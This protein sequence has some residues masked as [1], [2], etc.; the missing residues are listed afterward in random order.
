MT[1]TL[2]HIQ[3]GWISALPIEALLAEIMLD[4]VIDQ[5]I[6]L[7]RNDHNIYT[8][9]RIKIVGSDASHVVAIA[10]LPLSTTGKASA[11]TVANNMHRTFPNLKF[12]IMVGIAGGVWTAKEDV[13]LGDVVVG[14]PDDGGPGIIQYD[15][16][17]SIQNG[18]FVTKGAM[19]KAPDVLRSAAGVLQRKHM[20]RPGGDFV[21]SLEIAEVKRLASRPGVDNLFSKT[22]THQGGSSCENCDE[23]YLQS[24]PQ[25]LDSMPRVHYG[26]IA[27]GDQ[28]VKDAVF[29]EKIR[30]KHGIICFE[31]EAAGLD[32]FPCLVVRGISDYADTH[33]N[34]KWHAYAAATAAAYAKELLSVVPL[35]AVAE[36]PIIEI[37]HWNVP[38]APNPLFTGRESL[39]G[40]MEKHLINASLKKDRPVFVLQGIG[41]AGK[42]EAAIKFATKH[43]DKFWGIFWIDADNLQ[44]LE[45][46]FKE[47]ARMQTPPLAYNTP[48]DVL[49]WLATVKESW[50]L[51]LDNCDDGT[52]DFAKYIPSR[53]GSVILTTRLTD[54][55]NLGTW[56]NLD[57]LGHEIAVKL[58]LRACGFGIND[59]T[60]IPAAQSIVS[61][62]GQH[63]LAL[64]H[65]GAYIKK[66]YCTLGE[67][68]DFFRNERT[69]LMKFQPTQL[70]S[71]Y[72]S[73]YT[74]FEVSA[75]ALASSHDHDNHLALKLLDILA[76]LDRDAVEEDLF[77]RAFDE[78]YKLESESGLVWEENA[79]QRVR[80]RVSS[81]TEEDLSR[82]HHNNLNELD[83]P[84]S[85]SNVSCTWRGEYLPS[86]ETSSR[87]IDNRTF[88]MEDSRPIATGDVVDH[89]LPEF[90]TNDETGET[91]END[92]DDEDDKDEDEEDDGEID[93]LD[94]WHCK[95][96]RES[97]LVERQKFK[98]LRVARTRL[99]DLSLIRVNSNRISMH[100]LVHGWARTRLGKSERQYAW[101]QTLSLLAMSSINDRTWH[102]FTPKLVLHIDT[103]LCKRE[104]ESSSQLHL[105]VVRA[106]YR[107]G[108]HF[109][110]DRKF[111]ASL[112]IFMTISSSYEMQPHTISSKSED[113]EYAK[114]ECLRHLGRFEEMRRCVDQVVRSTIRWFTPESNEVFNSHMLLA[115]YYQDTRRL[116]DAVILLEKL[117]ERSWQI[118]LLEGGHN[119]RLLERSSTTQADLDD[120][121]RAVNVF[122]EKV[123]ISQLYPSEAS[124]QRLIIMK[125]L[126]SA[127]LELGKTELAV[128][129]FKEVLE[130]GALSLSP[131]E[132]DRLIQ[133]DQLAKAYLKLGN[134]QMAA[135]L[136][137]EVV[138]IAASSLPLDDRRRLM[139]M[140]RLAY[141]YLKLRK[142]DKAIKL[143]KEVVKIEAS[144][145][146]VND[147]GRLIHMDRLADGYLKLNKPDKAVTLLEEVVKIATSSLAIDDRDRLIY[148]DRLAAAY[149]QLEQPDKAAAVLE[150]VIAL[151]S[152][153]PND[154]ESLISINRLAEAYLRLDRPDE[155]VALLEE[156]VN[157]YANAH[158]FEPELTDRR[159]LAVKRCLARAYM[160]NLEFEKAANL[161]KQTVE[162]LSQVVPPGHQDLLHCMFQLATILLDRESEEDAYEALSLLEAVHDIGKER[163]SPGDQDLVS[164][165]IVLARAYLKTSQVQRAVEFLEATID[166]ANRDLPLDHGARLRLVS[167]LGNAYLQAGS[168]HKAIGVLGEVVE[169]YRVFFK[170]D[171]GNILLGMRRLA[172]AYTKLD[173]GDKM[174]DANQITVRLY[175]HDQM[176]MIPDHYNRE[177]ESERR[178]SALTATSN[179]RSAY[180]MADQHIKELTKRAAL[181][182]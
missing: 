109:Y 172:E 61:I 181:M 165:Q 22:Y 160:Q 150:Q 155:A 72:G 116:Q 84:Q 120:N 73:V 147:H 54:C 148:V 57:D 140:D 128:P 136:L 99:A 19:N 40:K 55:R 2:D 93:H 92:A 78:C 110:H 143:L 106:L 163:L 5:A 124:P 86:I 101:E 125:R 4:E 170:I 180:S 65:A 177:Q 114:A 166:V 53:G 51:I 133:M 74:T 32:A 79:C 66:G 80:C 18:E 75:K 108:W 89:E 179:P 132:P 24:R 52:I 16:G 171:D 45:E 71:R 47:I 8:Y 25:R 9:G 103:C 100:P 42:S 87:V 6:A 91:Y 29:A 1:L 98:R 113:I 127:Y 43:Q 157:T 142:P 169:L 35:T 77:V 50:L 27:S 178:T 48:K 175:K 58:L 41:G 96:V 118:P 85:T 28:V 83:N 11:A 154:L 176:R 21:S 39:L 164:T 130:I 111:E 159:L 167:M 129:L 144:S 107:L 38:R 138:E 95:K 30:V 153:Q 49:Q 97:G 46:G 139:Q 59:Q 76:F 161:M 90:R 7:P 141:A 104:D 158:S 15:L 34:D 168:V 81:S 145:L 82:N 31:M 182:F 23:A 63:A 102:D 174:E 37:T 115:A 68:V 44:S 3:I 94:I 134:P 173:Y 56:E 137:E 26:A 67:Y 12:G 10:P 146:S 13:R 62:L 151:K 121:E 17:K 123:Q 33:K 60:Q 119:V 20:R 70:S 112:S 105:N 131:N 117:Y 126:A 64:V 135:S 122:E 14:I 88:P 69:R 149:L 162:R 152:G 156:T 36:L